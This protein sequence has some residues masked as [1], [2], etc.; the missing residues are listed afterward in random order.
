MSTIR[1]ALVNS[2]PP[3]PGGLPTFRRPMSAVLKFDPIG[4]AARQWDEH[5]GARTVPPVRAVTSIMRAQ[6]ILLA[7]LNELLDPFD[8]TFPRYEALMV[9]YYS[10]RGSLPLGKVGDRL[11]VH[12]TSVTNLVDGLEKAGYVSRSAH[13]TDRRAVRSI[14]SKTGRHIAKSATTTLNASRFATKPLNAG[15]LKELEEILRALRIDAADF[16][17]PSKTHRKS[18]A[19]ATRPAASRARRNG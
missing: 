4:E 1:G 10:R 5:W 7:R 8:L 17:G 19:C 14:I 11:Q 3:H 2:H 9:L 18:N 12:K 13:P 15:Q 6:Q 16:Q